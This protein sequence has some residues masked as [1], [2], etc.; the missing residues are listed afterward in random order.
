MTSQKNDVNP[1][2]EIH[3]IILDM[4]QVAY[5]DIM[6][7]NLLK[8]ISGDYEKVGVRIALASCGKLLQQK[9]Q[10]AGLV[11]AKG[12]DMVDVYPTVHDAVVAR[13]NH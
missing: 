8:Q 10:A 12:D 6:G 1:E 3:S 9:L 5:I 2:M 11:K 4:S 7:L 13:K